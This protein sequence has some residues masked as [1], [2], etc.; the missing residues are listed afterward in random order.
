MNEAN[1]RQQM[2][3]VV[4]FLK[5]DIGTIRTGKA[6]PD[7]VSDVKISAYGGQQFLKVMELAS[8]TAPD[9][10]TIVIDPWDK[11]IIGEIRKG[12]QAANLGLNPQIDGQIVRLSF[13]PLT[14]EDRQ[15]FVK[16]LK[17]RLEQAKV[18]IRRVRTDTMKDIKQTFEQKTIS[19]DEK[20]H[21]EKI[22]QE[23]TDEFIEKIENIGEEKE[24]E[25]L[26][27]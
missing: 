15:K 2:D 27:Q 7:L 6:S 18:M 3:E 13:P 22:L 17:A 24:K 25:L 21:Q 26:L 16:L 4:G 14:T 12:L 11:S 10:E 23:L 9:P 8:I 1:V 19:E 5:S 20:F